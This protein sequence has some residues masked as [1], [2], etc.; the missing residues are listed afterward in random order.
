VIS[1]LEEQEQRIYRARQSGSTYPELSR[2]FGRPEKEIRAIVISTRPLMNT[3][4]LLL[5]AP[6]PEP[7]ES[8][9]IDKAHRDVL[10]AV[11]KVFDRVV[12]CGGLLTAKKATLAHGE[13]L[14]WIEAN[15]SFSNK[16]A[17]RYMEC[18][19][20][21]DALSNS[22]RMSNLNN[23]LSINDMLR[24]VRNNRNIVRRNRNT[25]HVP[26]RPQIGSKVDQVRALLR[27]DS[28]LSNEALM[29]RTGASNATVYDARREM[30]LIARRRV[31]EPVTT[32]ESMTVQMHG[33]VGT[34][35]INN[36]LPSWKVVHRAHDPRE[37]SIVC[38]TCWAHSMGGYS[39]TGEWY[40]ECDCED[41]S[42][43]GTLERRGRS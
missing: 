5:P 30:G 6:E 12:Y 25:T 43:T 40:F 9:A 19:A 28:T 8:E 33:S 23:P 17:E 18:Y 34:A 1:I 3:D 22:T 7:T 16:T 15:L 38:T 14:P 32:P 27:E 24:I 42:R 4:H 39:G 35:R 20:H 13:W 36:P 41:G 31:E 10:S 37:Q 29:E 21:R 26:E 2:V 11:E